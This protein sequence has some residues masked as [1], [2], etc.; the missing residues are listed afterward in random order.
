MPT[1][2]TMPGT[3]ALA[4]NIAI[5]WLDAPIDIQ[6]LP[7][8]GQKSP[9]FLSINPKGKVPVIAFEDGDVLTEAAAILTYIG[10]A[11]GKSGYERDS[12]LG[13]KE[14]E[15]LSYMTS[16]VHAA[17]GPHFSVGNFADSDDA[18]RQVQEHAYKTIDGHLKR[19]DR[20]LQDNGEWYLGERTFADAYL[21]VIARWVDLTPLNI[22]DYPAIKAHRQRMEQDPKV[23]LALERQD[24]KPVG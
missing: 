12:T 5:A 4:P 18:K 23:K 9:E 16:E 21:Y 19:L 15:A 22:S 11:H 14:G 20:T 17:F 10:A 3:C 24:M 13:R 2:Y 6:N 8:G 1:L 7:Y